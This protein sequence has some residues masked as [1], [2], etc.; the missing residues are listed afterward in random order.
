[1]DA[2]GSN[3]TYT[4]LQNF[5]ERCWSHGS[6]VEGTCVPGFGSRHPHVVPNHHNFS[7]SG[8]STFLWLWWAP[9]PSMVHRHT[10]RK[11]IHRHKNKKN[12]KKNMFKYQKFSKSPKWSHYEILWSRFYVDNERIQSLYNI[13]IPVVKKIKPKEWTKT[14]NCFDYF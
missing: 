10:W 14:S 7:S 8:S 13:P 2:E 3:F 4:S 12:H 11:N 6:V 9:G 1:M 5:Q